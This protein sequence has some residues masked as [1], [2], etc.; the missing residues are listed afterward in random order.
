V[1]RHFVLD[2]ID[3]LNGG[4]DGSRCYYWNV[5]PNKLNTRCKQS[6]A[7]MAFMFMLCVALIASGTL[8]F[9]K[10]R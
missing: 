5:E 9:L 7:D 10:S 2:K 6:Q 1:Y 8:A 4:C 3:I